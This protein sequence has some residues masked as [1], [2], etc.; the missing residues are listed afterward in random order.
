MSTVVDTLVIEPQ[1]DGTVIVKGDNSTLDNK[2]GCLVATVANGMKKVLHFTVTPKIFEAPVLSEKPVL[3]APENG[4]I[5]VTYA[6]TD[7][8]EAADESIINWYRA[9][10]KEGTDKVLVAQTTYVDS[11]AKPYSSYV[12]RLDD[13]NHY[14][15]CEVIPKRSNSVEGSSVFTAA[16]ELI[17]SAYVADEQKQSYNVDLEH[18]AYIEAENDTEEN[19]YE[20]KN[21]LEAGNWYG[22]FYLP[23]EYREGGE[24]S[25]KAYKPVSGELPYTYAQGA[26]GAS[27]TTGLQT[28]TQGA[29]LVYVDD[30]ARKDMS[31]TLT[32]SPHKTGAQGFGSAKQFID[33]YFKYDAKTMTGYG[34]RIARVPSISDPV[35]SSFA[36][37]SCTFT[38]MEYKNG[39]AIPLEDSVI[40]TAFLPGCTIKLDVTGNTFTAD[41]TTTSSQD[42]ASYIMPHE[43]H[44]SHVFENEVNSYS[45]IGFQH[46]GTSGAG[47]S[48]NRV[49]IHSVSVDYKGVTGE[50]IDVPDNDINNGND[51]INKD[52]DDRE[53]V[54]D[55]SVDV[56]PTGDSSDMRILIMLM[57]VS[58]LAI[59]MTVAK[60]KNSLKAFK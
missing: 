28:T 23:A 40:S 31:M 36:A 11:D 33:I 1:D 51:D 34:L 5:N 30:T 56:V 32:L 4:M 17:K 7:N 52:T 45:G 44:L 29:R 2:K 9:T 55:S 47:K 48:G 3:S 42:S 58:G 38:L 39:V 14:I 18:L 37:K 8:S 41:V 21:T 22:G 15:I 57:A 35:L 53:D 60:S 27:G 24:W 54:P 16:S 46:T 10:D 19:N 50:V 25:D 13:V 6:F 20:W 12:L 43:V 59:G 26:S 49:T